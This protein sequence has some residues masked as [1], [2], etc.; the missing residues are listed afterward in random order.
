MNVDIIRYTN[1]FEATVRRRGEHYV[2][3]NFIKLINKNENGEFTFE[4]HSDKKYEIKLVVKNK[5]I[6]FDCNCPYFAQG[7]N[8]KHIWASMVFAHKNKWF[9]EVTKKV[10]TNSILEGH[11]ET[12]GIDNSSVTKAEKLNW[13][14]KIIQILSTD[15]NRPNLFK[16]VNELELNKDKSMIF[17]IEADP[18]STESKIK[19]HFYIKESLK[20][21]FS[22]A[23]KK[24]AL[25]QDMIKNFHDNL[26]QRALWIFLGS[27]SEIKNGVSDDKKEF[28]YLE[29]ILHYP[30]LKELSDSGKLFISDFIKNENSLQIVEEPLSLRMVLKKENNEFAVSSELYNSEY[31]TLIHPLLLFKPPFC[32]F[33]NKLFRL[34]NFI[35]H[36]IVAAFKKEV[37]ISIPNDEIQNFMEYVLLNQNAPE[38]VLPEELEFTR[39]QDVHK[40]RLE[41]VK[42]TGTAGFV[43]YLSFKYGQKFIRHQSKERSVYD[44]RTQILFE[45]NLD[46]EYQNIDNYSKAV[47]VPFN[48]LNG[49][50]N[51]AEKNISTFVE[52][53]TEF[54][55]D[56]YAFQKKVQ[57]GSDY[58]GE[59]KSKQDWFDLS[60][61]FTFANGDV[62]NLPEIL[63]NIRQ[64]DRFVKLSDG[65]VGFLNQDW[66]TK[67]GQLINGEINDDNS[68]KLTKLQAM[69]HGFQFIEDQ[70]F[71]FDNKYMEFNKILKKLSELKEEE[72]DD[73]FKGELRPYQKMGLSWLHTMTDNH[74][75]AVLADDMGL[76]KTIQVLSLLS[77]QEGQSL[78]VAPKTLIFNWFNEAQKFT[79]HLVFHNHTGGDRNERI[80][81]LEAANVVITTYQTLRLDI[82]YFKNLKFKYFVFDEAHYIKNSDSQSYMA[83]KL[84]NAD[85]KIALTGTPVE[86]SLSD[87][88]S[89]LSV[90]TPGLIS[91]N[92]SNRF[93]RETDP[94]VLKGLSKSLKPFILR[95]TKEQVLTDLPDKSEQILYCELSPKEKN[96]YDELKK[97]YWSNLSGKIQEKG[98]ARSKIEILEA[99]LRLRQASCHLGLLDSNEASASSSKFDLL[100]ENMKT[101]IADGH[102]VLIFSQFTKLLGLL[103]NKLHESHIKFEYLDGKTK[104]REEI[105]NHFQENKDIHAFLIS[106]K[107]GGVGL[108]LT[109]ADYVY[110][111]DPWWNPAAESQAIDRAHRIGQKNKV[112]AYK[113]IAKGTVEEK[114]LELQ[115]A[116]KELAKTIVSNEASVFKGLE[117][118]DLKELFN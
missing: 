114:I 33:Q 4:S 99:L 41:I 14:E 94:D 97:Y 96:K 108:N 95:R 85:Q 88:F 79:P 32:I 71:T 52:K 100:L 50:F 59:I 11:S 80:K 112:F 27:K 77:H 70:R 38:L 12:K 90:T 115:K 13:K 26:D 116:K 74:I 66:V 53:S 81:S 105:V 2:K 113:I 37:E 54:G 109:S 101:V 117:I 42:E 61:Q 1:E 93:I 19:L 17:L 98:L 84:I 31:Q 111:L 56:V 43:V 21:S 68:I 39:S 69:F 23:I 92:V 106:L 48:E 64:G 18:R 7:Y 24:I 82:D 55:W 76:G 58:R 35:N 28:V 10:E 83:C 57:M 9:V 102:K 8:C 40:V 20:N 22:G 6:N 104:N 51:I 87:L 118:D 47:G 75:G 103:K 45:R 78:I 15:S 73:A 62:I 89:I 65:S 63:A 34:D 86:N 5:K 36:Q 46:F 110:I 91:D 16:Q 107:A 30:L 49:T 60:A 29:S 67:F 25:S 44:P 3:S 72:A